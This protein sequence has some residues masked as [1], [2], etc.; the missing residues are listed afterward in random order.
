MNNDVPKIENMDLRDWFA[1]QAM[2]CVYKYMAE[3]YLDSRQTDAIHRETIFDWDFNSLENF[4]DNCYD[5]ADFMMQR[6]E[7]K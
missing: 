2:Q 4:A 7:S 1:G 6:R 5:M 3:T